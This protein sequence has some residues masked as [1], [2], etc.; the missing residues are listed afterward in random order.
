M[1]DFH[2]SNVVPIDYPMRMLDYYYNYC[3]YCCYFHLAH[4]LLTYFDVL[5]HQESEVGT[6]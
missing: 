1:V 5:T 3:S 6:S 2:M 4:F